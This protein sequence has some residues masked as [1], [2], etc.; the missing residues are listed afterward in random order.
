MPVLIQLSSV[1]QHIVWLILKASYWAWYLSAHVKL[2][3]VYI[4]V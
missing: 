3:E 4:I 2:M 1:G